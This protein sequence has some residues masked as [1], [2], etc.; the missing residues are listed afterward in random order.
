[1]NKKIIYVFALVAVFISALS[2][3]KEKQ[4]DYTYYYP[5]AVVTLKTDPEDGKFFM[6][7][8]EKTT[9]LPVNYE[10]SPSNEE[11][12]AFVRYDKQDGDAGKYTSNVYVHWIKTIRTKSMAE[13]KGSHDANVAAYENDPLEILSDFP[14]VVEDGYFTVGFMTLFGGVAV[15][16]LNLVKGDKPGEVVLYHNAKGDYPA[17]MDKGVIA[18]R[19][20]D[21]DLPQTDGEIDLVVK[22]RSFSGDKE[23]TFKYIP[24]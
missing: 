19:L 20:D 10:K 23:H 17:K 15:H 8:D 3:E 11:T 13:S 12:R 7:L 2:C 21:L 14:T 24:R 1:M 16:E 9:L 5:N 18:F 4:P 22:W 6:Q